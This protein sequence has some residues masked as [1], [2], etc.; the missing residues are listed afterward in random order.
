MIHASPTASLMPKRT[1][2]LVAGQI[3]FLI[4]SQPDAPSVFDTN[5]HPLSSLPIE[6]AVF[7]AMGHTA[8]IAIKK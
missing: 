2:G 6:S 1:P 5:S 3:T 8:P 7:S 4:L